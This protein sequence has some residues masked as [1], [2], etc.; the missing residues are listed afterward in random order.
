MLECPEEWTQ[1]GSLTSGNHIEG[2]DFI[3][4][5]LSIEDCKLIC[6]ESAECKGFNYGFYEGKSRCE[7]H[8]SREPTSDWDALGTWWLFCSAPEPIMLVEDW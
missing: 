6:E 8:S 5:D 4:L 3:D 2:S 1:K 7:R